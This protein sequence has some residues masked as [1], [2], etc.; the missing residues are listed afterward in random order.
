M[1]PLFT[2]AGRVIT[3]TSS[4]LNVQAGS[5]AYTPT[6]GTMAI[7]TTGKW[8]FEGTLVSASGSGNDQAFGI[9]DIRKDDSINF[10]FLVAIKVD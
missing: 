3:Y 2:Y 7:P 5:A 9:S 6:T 4:N 1:N 8:Y 10:Y